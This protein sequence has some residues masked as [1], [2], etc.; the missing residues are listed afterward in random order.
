LGFSKSKRGFSQ[1]DAEIVGPLNGEE[2][3]IAIEFSFQRIIHHQQQAFAYR[4]GG[5]SVYEF[6]FDGRS[7]EIGV[8]W[9]SKHCPQAICHQIRLR[10]LGKAGH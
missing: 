2:F 8:C 5:L 9:V 3:S 10:L 1:G 6:G 7:V 4:D